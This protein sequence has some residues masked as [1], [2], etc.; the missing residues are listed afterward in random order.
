MTTEISVMYGSE[1][2]NTRSLS[3]IVIQMARTYK[4]N[5]I[6]FHTH[7]AILTYL[8]FRTN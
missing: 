3:E 7:I 8:V 4:V 6:F 2:V 1:K 5:L